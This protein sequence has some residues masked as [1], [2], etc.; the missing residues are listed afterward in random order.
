LHKSKVSLGRAH[1]S[2]PKNRVRYVLRQRIR[3]TLSYTYSAQMEIKLCN[4]CC[5]L[6]LMV[7]QWILVLQQEGFKQN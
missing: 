2:I 7:L 1:H 3:Y 5:R 4:G 6:D